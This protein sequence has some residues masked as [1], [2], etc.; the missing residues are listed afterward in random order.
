MRR[1][2]TAVVAGLLTLSLGT[3]APV[4]ASE[5][6]DAAVAYARGDYATAMRLWRPHAEQ[7]QAFAQFAVGDLYEYG[8]GVPQDYAEAMRWYRKAAEQGERM[9]E[10]N[11]GLMYYLGRGTSRD[12]TE[13]MKWLG[14]AAAHGDRL[15]QGYLGSMY[16]NGE[17]VPRDY[18]EAMKW[19]GRAATQGDPRAQDYLGSMYENG[20]SVP[21]DYVQAAKWFNLAAANFF[22]AAKFADSKKSLAN[23]DRVASKMTAGQIKEA[24]KLARE[25]KPMH[26]PKP[27]SDGGEN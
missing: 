18:T 10:C 6:D 2:L 8:L 27:K 16:A 17:G 22:S 4:W 20:E 14:R 26:E 9:A 25:W 7:G 5:S 24:K 12:Y 3:A 21:Q 15:A 11:L 13:A 19:L 23:R 1:M